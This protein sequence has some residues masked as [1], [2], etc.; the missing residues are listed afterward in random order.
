MLTGRPSDICVAVVGGDDRWT[1]G[2]VKKLAES[3]GATVVAMHSA[4]ELETK[5]NG[6]LPCHV[7]VI[8]SDVDPRHRWLQSLRSRFDERKLPIIVVAQGEADDDDEYEV[9]ATRSGANAYYDRGLHP[10]DGLLEKL[11]YGLAYE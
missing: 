8:G 4:E 5:I 7:L 11:V 2:L 10:D 1:N 3:L 9:E 6:H